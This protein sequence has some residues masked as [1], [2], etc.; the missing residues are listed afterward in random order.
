MKQERKIILLVFLVIFTSNVYGSEVTLAG[1]DGPGCDN[2]QGSDL[3][4]ALL[5]E[6]TIEK[7]DEKVLRKAISVSSKMLSEKLKSK[8]RVGIIYFNSQG[9]DLFESMRMGELIRNKMI[10]TAVT[11]DSVC[12][13]ACVIA[14]LGGVKRIPVGPVG[15]HSF[16]SKEFIGASDFVESSK[17]YNMVSGQVEIYL[18]KLRIPLS[19]LDEM[20]MV[21]HSKIK[22]LELDELSRLGVVGIDPV[23]AQ[24]RDGK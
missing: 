15:V 11:Y 6:G 17:K 13:S 24:I 3:C 22:I 1:I 14:Y 5:V 12:Y 9:G 21:P 10:A 7:G 23:Y 4:I 19:F 16:Y 18:K 20:K 8:A 2:V